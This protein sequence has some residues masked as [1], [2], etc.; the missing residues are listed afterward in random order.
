MAQFKS[1]LDIVPRTLVGRVVA[2]LAAAAVIVVG[3]FFLAVALAVGGIILFVV[4][5]RVMWLL[6]RARRKAEK[7]TRERTIEVDY[8]V[9]DE[10]DPR[11][12]RDRDEP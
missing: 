10:P 2:A 3:F 1:P 5:V 4:F 11:R 12:L 9:T 7:R 6:H 8:S